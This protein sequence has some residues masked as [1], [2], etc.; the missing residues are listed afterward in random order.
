MAIL[1]N[2]IAIS[3]NHSIQSTVVLLYPRACTKSKYN[4]HIVYIFYLNIFFICADGEEDSY[5][6]L[7]WLALAERSNF[8]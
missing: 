4:L 7:C 8:M 6:E 1:Q 5:D 3:V 2:K